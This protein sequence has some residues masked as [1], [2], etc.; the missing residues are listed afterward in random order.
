MLTIWLRLTDQL[1][2]LAANVDPQGKQCCV[3]HMP[4][5]PCFPSLVAPLK[6]EFR[7]VHVSWFTYEVNALPVHCQVSAYSLG[8][9]GFTVEFWGLGIKLRN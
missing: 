3:H 5:T 4:C 6:R 9:S 1:K 8:S 7:Q 2:I